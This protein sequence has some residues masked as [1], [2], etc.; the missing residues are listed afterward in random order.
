MKNLTLIILV[1]F[2]YNCGYTSIYKNQRIQSFNINIIET[3]GDR[4]MNNLIKNEIRLY[5]NKDSAKIYDLKINTKY[6]KEILTKDTSGDI[7]DYTLTVTSTFIINL[8]EK[9][10]IVK[11]TENI[12]I[13]NQLG[14]FEQ[15]NYEKN[16]KRNFASSLREKL[17]SKIINLNDN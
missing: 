1:L 3:K 10:Q 7:T 12:D 5:S 4:E 2:L 16:I 17:I 11:L 8:K 13:K 9:T 14:S 15:N 6:E